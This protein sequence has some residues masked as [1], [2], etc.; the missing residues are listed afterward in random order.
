M[1]EAANDLSLRGQR[2]NEVLAAYLQAVDAGQAPS[3]QELLARHPELTV[4][5]QAFFA[6]HDELDLLAGPARQVTSGTPLPAA[7]SKQPTGNLA[8][9]PTLTPGD[10]VGAGTRLRTFGDYELLEEIARG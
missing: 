4:E 5:L 3:R 1:T 7:W 9:D 6:D 10:V 8:G 2:V